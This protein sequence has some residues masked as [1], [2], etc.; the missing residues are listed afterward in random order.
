MVDTAASIHADQTSVIDECLIEQDAKRTKITVTEN[1]VARDGNG[2]VEKEVSKS[3][4]SI[5]GECSETMTVTV[6]ATEALEDCISSRVES[7]SLDLSVPLTRGMSSP[8]LTLVTCSTWKSVVSSQF[9]EMYFH[10]I[11]RFLHKEMSG[12]AK[13]FPPLPLIFNALNACK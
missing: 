6:E 13:I 9:S 3:V 12:N 1:L 2:V 10:D 11:T 8:L 7:S 5:D 4:T